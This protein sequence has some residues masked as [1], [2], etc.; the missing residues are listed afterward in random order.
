MLRALITGATA[1]SASSLHG[2]TLLAVNMCLPE[3]GPRPMPTH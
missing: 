1:D 3:C 2:C